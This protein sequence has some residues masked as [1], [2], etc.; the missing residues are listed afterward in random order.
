MKNDRSNWTVRKVT[1]AEAEELDI[2]YWAGK[3]IKERMSEATD[4]ITQVW[5]NHKNMHGEWMSIPDGKQSKA[6]TD[7][8]DF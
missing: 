8:D 7:E 5:N 6:Q 2:D 4:W 1:F 3:S